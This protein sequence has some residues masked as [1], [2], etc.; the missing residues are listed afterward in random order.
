MEAKA[1]T[2]ASAGSQ[3]DQ[4]ANKTPRD[5][6]WTSSTAGITR[7]GT[8]SGF[9]KF[10]EA[11][12]AKKFESHDNVP[13]CILVFLLAYEV[14]V[15]AVSGLFIGSYGAANN[16]EALKTT[17]ITHV[18]C[19]SPSLPLNFPDA[20]TYLQ[21][22]VPDLSSVSISM[23]F[24]EAFG[25]IDRALSSGGTVLVHCFMGRSRSATIILAYLIARRDFSLA[26]AFRELR[27]V[28]PQAQPNSG[29]YQELVAF[30]AK[31]K[32]IASSS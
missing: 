3:D 8:S 29:F 19:V 25:F 30:E 1:S 22:Q 27:Q 6:T 13:L 9:R 11:L 14:A 4:L 17:G 31:Q 26:D 23:Y 18:L 15:G 24:D 32:Q 12:M 28:R 20:F 21:L 7:K 5:S 2:A 10:R 16:F